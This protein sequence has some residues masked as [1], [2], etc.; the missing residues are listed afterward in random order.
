MIANEGHAR[1]AGQHAAVLSNAH[2]S[3]FCILPP[4]AAHQGVGQQPLATGGT[5]PA[6]RLPRPR[7]DE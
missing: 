6:G 3:G 5:R 1:L 4:R 2:P 7:R